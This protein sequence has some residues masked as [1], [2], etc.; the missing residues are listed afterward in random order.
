MIKEPKIYSEET[1]FEKAA[2]ILCLISG[3]ISILPFFSIIISCVGIYA[4]YKAKNKLY[5]FTCIVIALFAFTAIVISIQNVLKG[6]LL[7]V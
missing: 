3:I 1:S 7:W 2:F 5:L 4:S 6:E